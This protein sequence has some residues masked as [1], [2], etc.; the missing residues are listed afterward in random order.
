MSPNTL[1]PRITAKKVEE[2]E[3]QPQLLSSFALPGYVPATETDDESPSTLDACVLQRVRPPLP[4]LHDGQHR[5]T[6]AV[7]AVA[8]CIA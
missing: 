8:G 1:L 6:A 3:K 5:V 2:E 7:A 4:L